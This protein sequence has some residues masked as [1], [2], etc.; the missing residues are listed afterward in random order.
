MCVHDDPTTPDVC[1]KCGRAAQDDG[2]KYP[3]CDR[4]LPTGREGAS[5]GG[6]RQAAREAL[7]VLYRVIGLVL[8]SVAV[9]IGAMVVLTVRDHP[10]AWPAIPVV[11]AIGLGAIG[12]VF[13]RAGLRLRRPG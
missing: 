1:P 9:L 11:T 12:T 10:N 8:L 7:G 2:P 13:V 5:T 3:Y 6:F 4:Y